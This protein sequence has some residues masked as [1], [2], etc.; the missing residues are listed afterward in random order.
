MSHSYGRALPNARMRRFMLAVQEVMGRSGLTTVLRQ[1]R[2]Q[3]YVGHLPP[4]NNRTHIYAFEYAA[5]VQA[6]EN[7]YGRGARGSLIRIGHSAFAQLVQ[8]RRLT[9]FLYRLAFLVT[10]PYTRKLMALRWLAQEMAYPAGQ[11]TVH[12]DD[13]HIAFVDREGDLTYGRTRDSE[14]CWVTVGEIQEAVKW[15]TGLEHLVEEKNCKARGDPVC[16]FDIGEPLHTGHR[17]R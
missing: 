16:R 3:R 10:P 9:A 7:Y 4:D 11:V 1:G 2:L 5:L 6:I 12:L 13:R 15:A 17:R 14:I 8:S